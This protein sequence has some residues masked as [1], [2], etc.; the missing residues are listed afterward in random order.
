MMYKIYWTTRSGEFE[1][2]SGLLRPI[3]YTNYFG[4]AFPLNPGQTWIHLVDINHRYWEADPERPF[5]TL[6]GS[7]FWSV[8]FYDSSQH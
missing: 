8:R 5:Q 1:Q 2:T 3:R 4:E 7:A 6:V